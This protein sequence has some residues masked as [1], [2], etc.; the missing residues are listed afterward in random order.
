M[1]SRFVWLHKALEVL[2]PEN[3]FREAVEYG[4]VT[5]VFSVCIEMDG[6]P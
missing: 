6:W 2:F 5:D 1:R 3:E 4:L